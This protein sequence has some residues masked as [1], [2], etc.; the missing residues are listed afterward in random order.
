[1]PPFFHA[2][3]QLSWGAVVACWAW[4]AYGA[5]PTERIEPR[6][7]RL[8]AYW[9]PLAVALALLGPGEWFGHGLLREAFVPHSLPVYSLGLA[10][11]VAGA[12]LAIWARLLLGRNWSGVVALKQDHELIEAGPYRR[13]RHPI[14]S[15]LLLLFLGNAV[16]VGDWRGLLAVAIVA[17]SFWR[18]L[19]LEEAWL[20]ERFG[21]RYKDYM[22][23]T[24]ALVP[25]LL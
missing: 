18:K 11:C 10:L 1:M 2:G 13:V 24:R 14:Y 3:L 23:R 19:R 9:L 16:M 12:A 25:G 8:F 20:T 22:G 21:T 15:G 6:A 17:V 7:L 4:T 5:K